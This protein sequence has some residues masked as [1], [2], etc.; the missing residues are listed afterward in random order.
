M[1]IVIE[2]FTNKNIDKVKVSLD[3]KGIKYQII[4][5][6]NKVIKQ[7]PNKNDTITNNDTIY[8]IT[9]DTNM[10]VPNVLGVSSK[11]SKDI[12]QKLGLKV[13]LDGV[14]Y[15][16]EQSVAPGTGI[17]DGMEITLKLSPKYQ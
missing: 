2:S 17:T 4:G 7:S 13:K 5:N 10:T 15:V 3:S 8:L 6:G 1:E 16:T 11:V 12:L 9:N 14:G